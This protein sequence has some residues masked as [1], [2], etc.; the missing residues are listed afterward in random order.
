MNCFIHGN[1]IEAKKRQKKQTK[2]QETLIKGLEPEYEKWRKQSLSIERS[3]RESN[4]RLVDHFEAYKKFID[5]EDYKK[6]FTSQSKLHSTVLEEFM[7]YLFRRIP[8]IEAMMKLGPTRAYTNLFFA[9]ADLKKLQVDCGMNVYTKNQ[10]FAISKAVHISATPGESPEKE[11]PKPAGELIFVPVLSIECK[12]YIDKT[13]YEGAVATAERIKQGNPYSRFI[14]VSEFYD[15]SHDVD[16][17]H[18]KI[19]QI[20][21]LRKQKSSEGKRELNPVDKDVAWSLFK[22]T[23]EHLEAPWSDMES[24]IKSGLMI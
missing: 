16:P 21:V 18:S 20:Y 6:A 14:V 13:M 10:D 4:D 22:D 15:V 11:R 19:D 9:P 17:K 12:T 8:H 1:N 2:I 24:R 23:Q 5:G 7:Y 3:N